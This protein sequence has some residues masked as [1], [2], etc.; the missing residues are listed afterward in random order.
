MEKTGKD[1]SMKFIFL[2]L[3]ASLVIAFYWDKVP[4][5]KDSVHSVLNPTVGLLIDWNVTYGMIIIVFLIMIVMT[6]VQKYA[7]DQDTLKELK[8]EQKI[9]QEEMKKYKDHPE[10]LIELQKK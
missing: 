4:F 1:R 5:I 10:K 6:L 8:K 7:T 3:F 9:L 2:V